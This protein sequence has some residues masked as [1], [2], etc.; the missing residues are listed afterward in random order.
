MSKGLSGRENVVEA[1]L[2]TIYVDYA[3]SMT[4]Q[5]IRVLQNFIETYTEA[6]VLYDL[7]HT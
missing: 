2:H 5:T 3:G 1:W 4:D 6:G 7:A